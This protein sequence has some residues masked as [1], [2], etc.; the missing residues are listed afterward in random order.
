MMI[1]IRKM[2]SGLWW[3]CCLV[4]IVVGFFFCVVSR[5]VGFYVW[6]VVW[7]LDCCVW[8][9]DVVRCLVCGCCFGWVGGFIGFWI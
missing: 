6:C 8:V 7:W 5:F 3:V 2:V 9:C 1:R 4:F